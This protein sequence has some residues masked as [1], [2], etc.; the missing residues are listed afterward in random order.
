MHLKAHSS[1]C[2]F[3]AASQ[4]LGCGTRSE[5]PGL[6]VLTD[7]SSD[8]PQARCERDEDCPGAGDLCRPVVCRRSEG[9]CESLS[10]VDCDD[11]DPCT[12]DR[13]ESSTGTCAHEPLS[14]DLD[15]DGFN[16]ARAGYAPGEPES[17]GDDCD[18]SSNLAYP[19]GVEVCD[20]VDNDCN[21]IVDDGANFVPTGADATILSMG[22]APAQP[23]GF[24]WSGI[25]AAG[26]LAAYDGSE[27]GKSRVY[28]QRVG[29]DGA[30][31]GDAEQLTMVNADASGGA[32]VW[33][34]DRYG[35][36]WADR[37]HQ[38]YEV[39]FTIVDAYG[40]KLIADLRLSAAA[41][42]SIY[43]RV[44]FDG[45]HFV[46]AWQDEREGVFTILARRIAL[47]GQTFTEERT[48][49]PVYTLPHEAPFL[50]VGKHNL[51]LA[52]VSGGTFERQVRF[53]VFDHALSPEA[54]DVSLTEKGNGGA[55][56][57]VVWN[58]DVYVVAWYD[59]D[60]APFTVYGAVVDEQGNVL[61]P[62][63]PLATGPDHARYP[64]LMPLGDRLMVVFS[65]DRDGNQGYEL[66]AK[67]LT[68]ALEA[69]SPDVRITKSIGHSILP[70]ATF[71]PTGDVGVLFRDDRL[72]E[73]HVFFTRLACVI[74]D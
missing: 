4:V 53:R 68:G 27:G 46:V 64:W 6:Y 3:I 1:L 18:D 31:A 63:T 33:T 74:P 62:A 72:Q 26:Y 25:P 57:M 67:M 17:C 2:V 49:V 36:A 42:F 61:T 22:K 51:G 71:G 48:L 13:C 66:Y 37:R 7:A 55:F 52:W 20:G 21:G 70:V 54:E 50:S 30:L 60:A 45:S 11:S 14:L 19:G 73:Q 10:E 9:V 12:G 8:V 5:I 24:G 58:G 35:V 43:P 41:G 32:M 28:L 23:G 16:G 39:Y 15:R 34:G 56:P 40:S 69:A 44:V 47:D 65:D 38:D 29:V 59:A